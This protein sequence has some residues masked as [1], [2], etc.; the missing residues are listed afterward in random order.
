MA[1]LFLI[2]KLKSE[3][4]RLQKPFLNSNDNTAI[5]KS[6]PEKPFQYIYVH[7]CAACTT[8]LVTAQKQGLRTKLLLQLNAQLSL[9]KP[10]RQTYLSRGRQYGCCVYFLN[11]LMELYLFSSGQACWRYFEILNPNDSISYPFLY[12]NSLNSTALNYNL[13]PGKDA[14]FGWSRSFIYD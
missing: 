5:F 6:V 13:Q 10:H 14:P 11:F 7:V 3:C 12:F 2:F 9:N 8:Q 1:L 4:P